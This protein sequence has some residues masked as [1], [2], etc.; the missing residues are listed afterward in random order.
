MC[1]SRMSGRVVDPRG[2]SA[3]AIVVAVEATEPNGASRPFSAE[4]PSRAR[5]HT[6]FGGRRAT[7]RYILRRSG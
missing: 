3:R 4:K 1:L 7:D 2:G 6:R 5:A